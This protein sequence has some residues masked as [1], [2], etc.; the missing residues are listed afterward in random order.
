[1]GIS[2]AYILKNYN[3]PTNIYVHPDGED[4]CN[5]SFYKPVGSLTRAFALV[6]ATRLNVIMHPGS[7]AEAAAVAWPTRSNVNVIGAGAGLTVI[8]ATGTSVITITPGAQ[9]ATFNCAIIGVE[10]DHSAG[11]A[12]SGIKFDNTGMGKRLNFSM[13]NCSSSVDSF[14]DKTLNVATHG[15]A[16]NAIRL[17]CSGDGSQTEIEGVIYFAVNNNGD[18]IH[19]ENMWLTGG[20]DDDNQVAAIQTS[21]TALE[22]RIR[23]FKCIV[24]RDFALSGGN[25]LQYVTCVDCF[26]WADYNDLTPENFLQLDT[27]E[28]IGSHSEVIVD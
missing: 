24:P 26:S 13:K 21:S 1:M 11:S 22:A 9:T 27:G 19:L 2:N 7:Y 6:S 16:N 15:D 3:D 17:Y 25:A 23:L 8:S 5:G 12:Q 4:A 20:I 14:A 18:R 10:I 28:L